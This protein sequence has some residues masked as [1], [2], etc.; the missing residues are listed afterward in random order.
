MCF[1][2]QK[3]Q[4]LYAFAHQIWISALCCI[5]RRLLS[6]LSNDSYDVVI[7]GA[8]MGGLACGLELHKAGVNFAIL[9]ASDGVGGRVRTDQVDGFLL[10][11]G[12][13]IF[14]TSYEEAQAMLDYTALDLKPFY[15]GA[16]DQGP[17]EVLNGPETTTLSRLQAE[18]F[19]SAIIDRFF[20]PFLGGIFF[21]RGL[22][23]T[24]RLFEFVMRCLA[25]GQ[26]CLPAAGISAV[27]DQ[28]AAK[29]PQGFIHTGVGVESVVGSCAGQPGSVGLSGGRTVGARRAIVVATDAPAARQLLGDALEA[30][31][32][33]T[34]PG[35]GTCN[36]YFRAPAAP[37][38]ENILYLNGESSGLVNN[39][40]FPSTVAPSYAPAGQALVSVITIGTQP[41]MSDEQLAEA[42]KAEIAAWFDADQTATWQLLRVYHIPF[43]QPNQAPPNNFAR[44]VQLSEGLYVCGDHR[45]SPRW[46]EPS[47]QG[48][49]LQRQSWLAAQPCPLDS[50]Q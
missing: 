45:D 11:R 47:S 14:L 42:V 48:G 32:S 19:S 23:T 20:R 26:N 29:L 46:T 9:E 25:T 2:A 41:D 5:K 49:E 43:A 8:G 30:S 37:R 12:F 39:V 38:E 24:S 3:Q 44:P 1:A 16:L 31:P 34:E 50:G 33:K 36:L 4:I 7:V 10:D 22:S 15:A 18:G 35:V 21:D 40:C 17:D 6:K 28:L 13:Q 27:A